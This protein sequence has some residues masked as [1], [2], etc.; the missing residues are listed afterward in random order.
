MSLLD[1]TVA[2]FVLLAA[3]MVPAAGQDPAEFYKDKTVTFYVGLSAGGGYDVNARLVARHIGKY[4]PGHPQVI[5]RNMPGGGGMVMTNYLANVAPRDGLHIGAPQ[6]G[7]PFEPLLGD[8]SNAKFDAVKLNWIGSANTDT[9]V[10]VVHRRTGVK[11]WQDLRT[12]AND[13]I[14][15]GT[16]IGTESVT[17]PYILRN[18]LGFKFR[19]ITGYPGGSEVNLA[20]LRG[21]VDGRGTFSW[22]SLKPHRKEWVDSGE[23]VVLYQQG[24]RKHPDLPHVPLV[25]DLTEDEEI[26]KLLTIQFTAFELGRP[27]F[28]AEGVPQDRVTALRRAFDLAMK[29]KDL[30]ADALKLNQEVNPF[31]GAAM[32]KVLAEI[33]ATPRP[34]LMRLAEAIKSKPNLKVI[35]GAKK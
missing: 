21:E 28:V 16:G 3:S 25:T 24:L 11:S 31:T 12:R 34:L 27:Y 1:K 22:T 2:A 20:I 33:Y 29:D 14:V 17:V 32:Q 35:E 19:V 15:A 26:R 8:H 9:S 30:L 23:L 10:A 4:I 7:I 6:R 5:V 13:I 18:L